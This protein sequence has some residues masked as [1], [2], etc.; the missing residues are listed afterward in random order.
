MRYALSMIRV[1]MIFCLV[2]L[3]IGAHAQIHKPKPAFAGQPEA[4]PPSKASPPID[5][6]TI[7]TRF[8]GAWSIS[9]LPVGNFRVTEPSGNMRIVHPDGSIPT[10]L[11]AVAP[12]TP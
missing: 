11:A 12:R 8:S 4:P 5:V 7:A 9:F 2:F 3:A 10:P 6:Q 1:R